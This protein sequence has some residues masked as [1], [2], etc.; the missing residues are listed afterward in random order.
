MS[1]GNGIISRPSSRTVQETLD[2][3]EDVLRSKGITIFARVDHAGEAAKVKLILPPTQVLIFGS[4]KAG[5]PIMVAAPTAAI[6]LP[7]KAL[8]WQGTDGKVWLS[9]NDPVYFARRFGLTDAEVAP[10]AGVGALVEQA[11]K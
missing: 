5:T 11:L 3:L 7:L 10:I 8:A 4:P 1:T 6:D 2:Q 9:Y